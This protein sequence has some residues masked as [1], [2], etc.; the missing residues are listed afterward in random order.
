MW[1]RSAQK[2]IEELRDFGTNGA[3]FLS[4]LLFS[5][6]SVFTCWTSFGNG[7][8]INDKSNAL[9]ESMFRSQAFLISSG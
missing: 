2:N 3:P 7:G 9:G 5:I 6:I 1:I 8:I 4:V